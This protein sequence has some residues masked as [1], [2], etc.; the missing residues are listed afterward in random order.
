MELVAISTTCINTIC[1]MLLLVPLKFLGRLIP[2]A[3][4]GIL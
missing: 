2:L 4:F 1:L 3:D